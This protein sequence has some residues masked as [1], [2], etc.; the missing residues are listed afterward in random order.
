MVISFALRTPSVGQ[1]RL[2]VLLQTYT[3]S[4]SYVLR[5]FIYHTVQ[6]AQDNLNYA[7]NKWVSVIP[8]TSSHDALSVD[9]YKRQNLLFTVF[10]F[11]L[12]C[13][14]LMTVSFS[15]CGSKLTLFIF[16]LLGTVI[17]IVLKKNYSFSC[18]TVC[19]FNEL[20][21]SFFFVNLYYKS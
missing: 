15:I 18:I 14:V 9:V 21:A 4:L 7:C 11:L 3:Q 20:I 19:M 1:I 5:S 13:A 10:S 16:F 2:P 8:V 12:N 17:D 6:I